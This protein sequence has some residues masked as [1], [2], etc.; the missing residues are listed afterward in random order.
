MEY[1]DYSNVFSVEN[2][3]EF[4]ENTRINEHV[5]E[6]KEDKQPL[7]GPIYSLGPV[8]LKMLNTYI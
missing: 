4:P 8:K 2:V 7:F 1:S 6:Q 5:I 3:V